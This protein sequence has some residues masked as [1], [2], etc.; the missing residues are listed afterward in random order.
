MTDNYQA[1]RTLQRV[2][3]VAVAKATKNKTQ[4][5]LWSACKPG[6]KGHYQKVF[7][8]QPEEEKKAELIQLLSEIEVM[9]KIPVLLLLMTSNVSR[10]IYNTH[11]L[12]AEKIFLRRIDH[13]QLVD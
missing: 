7:N 5:V 11:S 10:L 4:I 1:L 2:L 8:R 9:R 13:H 12:P 6:A 3:A